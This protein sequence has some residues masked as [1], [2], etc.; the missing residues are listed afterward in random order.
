MRDEL[1]ES[2]F[3]SGG[4]G[5]M[6]YSA[7]NYASTSDFSSLLSLGFYAVRARFKVWCDPER[8]VL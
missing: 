1:L 5:W 8:R 4:G 6:L 7:D 2:Y 3:Y